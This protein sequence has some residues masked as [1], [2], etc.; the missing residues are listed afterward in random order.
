MSS[1]LHASLTAYL[2]EKIHFSVAC[3][4]NGKCY[5]L[6]HCRLPPPPPHP[7]WPQYH[8]VRRG[9][10]GKELPLGKKCPC[11][12]VKVYEETKKKART[13]KIRPLATRPS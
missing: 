8:F 4:K 3:K 10:G 9:G 2:A 11:G 7:S 13:Q 12:I 1:S 5:P 6:I